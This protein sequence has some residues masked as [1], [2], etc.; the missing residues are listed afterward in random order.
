MPTPQWLSITPRPAASLLLPHISKYTRVWGS[1]GV[2][3]DNGLSHNHNPHTGPQAEKKTKAGSMKDP[4]RAQL[5]FDILHLEVAQ[6][7]QSAPLTG[8]P[9]EAAP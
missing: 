1:S 9:E 5:H 7:P 8:E 6:G 3:R 2:T 4:G